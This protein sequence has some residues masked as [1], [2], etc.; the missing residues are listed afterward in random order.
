MSATRRPLRTIAMYVDEG[1]DLGRL[2]AAFDI[3]ADSVFFDLEDHVPRKKL[4][5]ARANIRAVLEEHGQHETIF[6]RVN[7]IGRPEALADLDAIV[8]PNLYGVLLP[9]V[10]HPDE[11]RVLDHLLGLI[12]LERGIDVGSIAILPLLES[13]QGNRLAYEVALASPRV[14]HMGGCVNQHGDP[15]RSIGY[16]WTPEMTETSYIRQKVLLD[17]RSA[18]VPHPV[19]G[20]WNPATD[21]EG[22]E[23]FSVSCRN[24]GYVGLL[25]MP[26]PAHVALVNRVFTPSQE[27]V[28]YW[29]EVIRLMGTVATDELVP[30]LV[31]EGQAV[32]ANRALWGQLRLELA[33]AF[34]VVPRDDRQMLVADR[35]GHAAESWRGIEDRAE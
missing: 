3:G 21:L 5:A 20:V 31:V 1:D 11:V 7:R 17:A 2:R 27:E 6:V 29:A 12:E 33:A 13:A 18:G 26:I 10:E 28:D 15:A 23:R 16:Q 22:L 8:C 30:D 25:V 32:P 19:S 34:G 24:I 9:K 14:A 4:P 35:V